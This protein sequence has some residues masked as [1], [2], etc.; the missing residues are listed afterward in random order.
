VINTRQVKFMEN[1][2]FVLELLSSTGDPVAESAKSTMTAT[3]AGITYRITGRKDPAGQP[4]EDME[5]AT[6]RVNSGS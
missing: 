5:F 3:N 6:R 1:G 2:V 4:L